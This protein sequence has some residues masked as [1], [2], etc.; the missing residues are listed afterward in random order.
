MSRK[1]IS[2]NDE[3]REISRNAV[4]QTQGLKP[5]NSEPVKRT[6]TKQAPQQPKLAERLDT[7][8]TGV[9]HNMN[10]LY[11][12]IQTVEQDVNSKLNKHDSELT[13]LTG[14]L[15]R[16]ANNLQTELAEI[17][18]AI[19]TAIDEKVEEKINAK[20]TEILDSEEYGEDDLDDEYPELSDEEETNDEVEL[21]PETEET[22]EPTP[23]A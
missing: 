9:D 16:F 3:Q 13:N 14:T 18:N 12:Y 1:E 19:D 20:L 8:T 4:S 17:I 21:T 5:A 2:T 7:L 6:K 10:A 23:E 15:T 22:P 11:T